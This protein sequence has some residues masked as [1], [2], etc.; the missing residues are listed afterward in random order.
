MRIF[1]EKDYR[2]GNILHAASDIE[3]CETCSEVCT[4][5]AGA[6]IQT[7]DVLQSIRES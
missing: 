6:Q 7:T 3:E 5:L 1:G 2:L 4:F